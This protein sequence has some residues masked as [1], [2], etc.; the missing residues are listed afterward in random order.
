MEG[1][2]LVVVTWAGLE[3]PIAGVHFVDHNES[4]PD[5][6]EARRLA[7]RIGA[8]RMARPA[9]DALLRRSISTTFNGSC[10]G[11][12]ISP[13]D[14]RDKGSSPGLCAGGIERVI[15]YCKAEMQ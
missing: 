4:S 6:R 10:N 8:R 11:P 9:H 15:T 1:V 2:Q 5:I 13:T 12:S 14:C 7:H 3:N